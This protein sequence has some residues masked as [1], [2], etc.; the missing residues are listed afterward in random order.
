MQY[1]HILALSPNDGDVLFA[2]A[3]IA[4]QKEDDAQARRYLEKMVRW[5]KGQVKQITI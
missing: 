1:E 2:L 5:N 3:L 4:M